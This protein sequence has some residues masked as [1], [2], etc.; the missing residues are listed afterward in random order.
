MQW[1]APWGAINGLLDEQAQAMAKLGPTIKEVSDEFDSLSDAAIRLGGL[2]A[3]S[4][5]QLQTLIS[6][7]EALGAA[8]ELTT[9]QWEKYGAAITEAGGRG[10]DAVMADTAESTFDV[11]GALEVAA[12][13]LAAEA[14]KYWN[15]SRQ[16]ERDD[17]MEGS[18][19]GHQR[20]I[21]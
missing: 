10:L 20:P 14:Q 9:E 19:G 3:L 5:S 21:G 17:A 6:N 8:G 4:D 18:L 16:G 11:A 7:Y 2:D 1:R 12:M 15:E 13:K